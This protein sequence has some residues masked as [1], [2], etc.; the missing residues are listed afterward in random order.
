[1]VSARGFASVL[2]LSFVGCASQQPRSWRSTDPYLEHA[3]AKLEGRVAWIQLV[4]GREVT[5][6]RQVAVGAKEVRWRADGVNRSAPIETVLRIGVEPKP[7]SARELVT[8]VGALALAAVAG[9][10]LA[11]F[12][13]PPPGE[14]SHPPGPIERFYAPLPGEVV[15]E[16]PRRP[17]P[18]AQPSAPPASAR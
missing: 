9:G 10:T 14:P 3:N 6:A 8:F 12:G 18:Q 16:A 15:W 7:R 1:M 17:R 2:L 11:D 13:G 4:D 5:G